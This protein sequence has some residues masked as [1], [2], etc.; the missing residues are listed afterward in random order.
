MRRFIFALS[1]LVLVSGCLWTGGGTAPSPTE[2]ERTPTSTASE[3]P[4]SS[5]PTETFVDCPVNSRLDWDASSETRDLPKFPENVTEESVV[6]YV[7]EFEK[8]FLYNARITDENMSS[9]EISINDRQLADEDDEGYVVKLHGTLGTYR[10]SGLHGDIRYRVNYY[11][12]DSV[13]RRGAACGINGAPDPKSA[14]VVA[15]SSD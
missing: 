9:V 14:P 10:D 1:L 12:T 3:E 7:A 4:A 6:E 11:V 15:E 13:A 2:T 5:S 8:A